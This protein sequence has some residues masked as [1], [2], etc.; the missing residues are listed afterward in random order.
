M[1]IDDFGVGNE[2]WRGLW[3]GGGGREGCGSWGKGGGE[4]EVGRNKEVGLR[5]GRGR[6]GL[7]KGLEEG[8]GRQMLNT[9]MVIN[10]SIHL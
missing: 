3:G 4:Q 9:W 7:G 1:E 2:E 6:E 10:S 5:K 8:W